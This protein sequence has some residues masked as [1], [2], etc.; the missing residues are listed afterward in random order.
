MRDR[1][2]I[3]EDL[4]SLEALLVAT[5]GKSDQAV[6][7]LRGMS[8]PIA[9]R[10]LL[11]VLIEESDW[12]VAATELLG[13]EPDSAWVDL[14]CRIQA[15][16]GNFSAVKKY[17]V[18]AQGYKGPKRFLLYRCVSE[19]SEGL[20]RRRA[21]GQGLDADEHKS[22]LEWFKALAS[23]CVKGV[24]AGGG[25]SNPVDTNVCAASLFIKAI[26]DDTSNLETELDLLLSSPL[27]FPIL[28]A[29]LMDEGLIPANRAVPDRL[30]EDAPKDLQTLLLATVIEGRCLENPR[31]AF[32]R[33]LNARDIAT[34]SDEKREVAGL[35][36]SLASSAGD[37]ER[38]VLK[39]LLPV[40]LGDISEH[41]ILLD[42]DQ[43]AREGDLS[44][45][46][47]LLDKYPDK[48][49]PAWLRIA[50]GLNLAL[51][52]FELAATLQRK[53]AESNPHWLNYLRWAE[54]S[55]FAG[56]LEEAKEAL[57]HALL[58]NPNDVQ[59]RKH[60][61]NVL[62]GMD[63]ASEAKEHLEFVL[64]HEPENIEI[65]R[66]LAQLSIES[67]DPD[68][69]VEV[70]QS[71]HPK[72]LGS[73]E[74]TLLLASLY[75]SS[76][77]PQKSVQ[78]V[79]EAIEQVGEKKELL[80]ALLEHGYAAATEDDANEALQKL[81]KLKEA[82]AVEDTE[83]RSGSLDEFAEELKTRRAHR[84]KILE[85]IRKARVPWLLLTDLENTS[86]WWTWA[87]RTQELPFV[88]DSK[89]GKL[90]FSVYATNAMGRDQVSEEHIQ[91]VP[92]EVPTEGSG[93][94]L[95]ISGLI[96]LAHLDLL[97]TTAKYF[98]RIYLPSAYAT[99]TLRDSWVLQPHQ[100]SEEESAFRIC[101]LVDSSMIHVAEDD[102]LGGKAVV[103]EYDTLDVDNPGRVLPILVY[104]REKGLI[105]SDQFEASSKV[106]RRKGP[107]VSQL[108][109]RKGSEVLVDGHTFRV[110]VKQ[111]LANVFCEYFR[112]AMLKTHVAEVRSQTRAFDALRRTR[113][114]HKAC[115]N[116]IRGS[117]RFQF[118][119]L[120][121]ELEARNDS[122]SLS[123]YLL[124]R[125]LQI[126]LMADD[127]TLI[128][129]R[130]NE[131]LDCSVSFDT[132]ALISR[133]LK[134]EYLNLEKYANCFLKLIKWRYK[135]LKFPRPLLS[136]FARKFADGLPGRPLFEI[137]NYLHDCCSDGA[138]LF[139][140]EKA[141]PPA[142]MGMAWAM[143]WTRN[144]ASALA[145]IWQDESFTDE[146]AGR[147][148]TWVAQSLIPSHFAACPL[149]DAQLFFSILPR[150]VVSHY[151]LRTVTNVKISR[152]HLGLTMLCSALGL[153][154]DEY[155][156]ITSDVLKSVADAYEN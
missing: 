69:A 51:G 126:P 116:T 73:V 87:L 8:G 156:L 109:L 29:H 113:E 128:A 12:D 68:K 54:A 46:S 152:Q 62:F 66:S 17:L 49:Y 118:A 153:N 119:A 1:S 63:K 48:N 35:L 132:S 129:L 91:V 154:D 23:V 78:L 145:D 122:R 21:R 75:R 141:D 123:A 138:L 42:A 32:Y 24:R 6:Q 149:A 110:L 147:L 143:S 57:K 25:I 101:E 86:P 107:S 9:L 120:P 134:D 142:S 155:S 74:A 89:V 88:E 71:H 105:D 16:K 95:D 112:I 64:E 14:G 31:K 41:S 67:G 130:N 77:N 92:I 59:T 102:D 50:V 106:F 60:L 13:K 28:A 144:V 79:K 84:E 133:L 39:E 30:V 15:Y 65:V 103:D 90:E 7:A 44:R 43:A 4:N 125:S 53:L 131:K 140:R 22:F 93:I 33:L 150:L 111:E 100:K 135:F 72:I 61:I 139:G 146:Q 70:L 115:W 38:E 151:L 56:N 3:I 124:S 104:L 20:F 137:A 83:L 98:Q 47:N 136:Y 37:D 117:E 94:V 85:H 34:S 76:G 114:V 99:D 10:R 81:I 97:E 55:Y 80:F 108:K 148:T 45:A 52:E 96:T 11:I 36:S 19:V 18:F 5:S 127:R 58:R 27:R 40:W 82:G 26:T 2:E 121:K